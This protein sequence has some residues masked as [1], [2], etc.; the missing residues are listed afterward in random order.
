M[1]NTPEEQ[2]IESAVKAVITRGVKQEIEKLAGF[3]TNLLNSLLKALGKEH[4][5]P[6]PQPEPKPPQRDLIYEG[7]MKE[8]RRVGEVSSCVCSRLDSLT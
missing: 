1:S 3:L 2:T 4:P 7:L 8:R 6:A 5:A